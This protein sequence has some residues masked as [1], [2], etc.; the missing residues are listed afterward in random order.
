[1]DTGNGT[2][3]ARCAEII[4][5]NEYANFLVKYENDIEGVYENIEPECINII[6]SR[7]LVAYRSTGGM[8]LSELFEFGFGYGIIP[9]CYGLMDMSG[10]TAIGADRVRDLPGL[11]LTG[12]GVLIGFVDTGI[13]YTNPLFQNADG[14]TRIAAIWDQTEEVF[15][16]GRPAFGYG[17]EFTARDINYALASD[18]PYEIVP[19]RDEDGHGTF[20]AS[21]AAGGRL[22]SESYTGVAPESDILVVK[23]KQVKKNLRD[24]FLVRE[25][26]VCYGE[27]DVMLGI[28]Y[29]I[30]KAN[31]LEKPLIICLGIGTTQGDHNGSTTLEEYL[32]TLVNLRGLC[33]VAAGGNELGYGG[34][35]SGNSRMVTGGRDDMEIQVG[36]NERGFSLEIWGSTPGLLKIAILSP[37]GERLEQIPYNRDGSAQLRFLYE[38]TIVYAENLVVERASGDQL[39][40]LRFEDPAEGIWT[41]QVTTVGSVGRGF[42]A[43]LPL[44]DFLS[45]GSGTAF[46]QS[47]PN[48]TICSPANGRGVITVAGY[49]HYT[50]ALYVNSSR[51]YTRSGVIKPD[52]TA[53]AVDAYGAFMAGSGGTVLFTRRSGTSIAAAYTAGAAALLMEWALVKGNNP[54]INTE[55]I[56]Q[57]M[58][59]G[60][61]HVADTDY[62][63][64]SWGWGVLDVYGVF[65]LMRNV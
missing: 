10:V 51:G 59:R 62:P 54:F 56:R 44:H 28:K 20:L 42:D 43:W 57:L 33:T 11:S 2:D 52:I 3:S 9:K 6:N 55:T 29:M 38:G 26:A 65:E 24:F 16:R 4:Y 14:T 25:D 45:V 23:L 27:D 48:I 8:D 40:F 60:V 7:F 13:D 12:Q 36:P 32:D 64:R 30:D 18:S 61:Q 58:I 50:K 47:D 31:V 15:G 49:N 35:Y 34:H 5:S 21:V 22:E 19:S 41:V 46:V 39:V 63:N 53:P 17:A 37:T 1:M